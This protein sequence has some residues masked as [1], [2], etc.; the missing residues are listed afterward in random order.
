MSDTRGDAGVFIRS[1][2]SR[3][4]DTGLS[5]CANELADVLDAFGS[6]VIF[7]ETIGV[8][9]LEYKVRFSVH[10]TL[11]VLVPDA[12]DDIQSMK[13][14]LME[15]GD[16][17]VVNKADRAHAERYA[18]DLR[19]MLELRH[20]AQG[21]CP[22]VVSTIATKGD[23]V[24]QLVDAIARHK[25]FLERNGGIEQKRIDALRNRITMV[26]E[27]KL[28]ELFWSDRQIARALD[29]VFQEVLDGTKSPYEAARELVAALSIGNQGG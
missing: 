29:S 21:W 16:I 28:K 8:G 27:E 7:L 26:A 23:G 11:V 13:S 12:G 5:A 18:D 10:T 14:G 1:I 4:S 25:S 24:Q 9:Q 3:G 20:C 22:H 2:A 19:G 17:F 15:I 6:D